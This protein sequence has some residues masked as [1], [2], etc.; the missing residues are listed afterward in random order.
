MSREP[1][2]KAKAVGKDPLPPTQ[3]KAMG[4]REQPPVTA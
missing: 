3:A 1:S 2:S 4:A